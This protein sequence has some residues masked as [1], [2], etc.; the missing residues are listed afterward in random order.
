MSQGKNWIHAPD[1]LTSGHIA[2]L[3]KFLGV[4]EA[5]QP[6]G[7]E[8]VKDC[9]RKLKLDQEIRRAEGGGKIPKAEVT[10]SIDGVA[11]QEPKGKGILHQFPLH[12]ISY[13]ADDKTEKKFFS[14]IAKDGECHR[15]FVFSSE[16]LAEEIT[17]TIGQAF[18]LAYRRF[19]ETSGKEMEFK[20]EIMV[21]QKRVAEL[22]NENSD[23]RQQ[24]NL[25][26]ATV[27]T[28]VKVSKSVDGD[29]D[30]LICPPVPPR[31]SANVANQIFAEFA[32]T[33]NE[34]E[35]RAQETRKSDGLLFDDD[36]I[37]QLDSKPRGSPD[38]IEAPPRISPP[39]KA[40]KNENL[41]NGSSSTDVF[42][43]DPFFTADDPFGMSDFGTKHCHESNKLNGYGDTNGFNAFNGNNNISS[44][45]SN[46]VNYNNISNVFS[47]TALTANYNN[48]TAQ[49]N[50]ANNIK[51]QPQQ[52][53]TALEFLDKKIEEMKVGFSR[54]ILNDDFPLESL[55]PLKSS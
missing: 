35:K 7:I 46:G 12:Q 40:R 22:E 20:R 11:V 6:K 48:I 54:G 41:L 45:G 26:P 13:C 28:E 18:D 36:H 50:L 38:G 32:K 33:A 42:S 9:I 16:K 23:L 43:S 2:Y 27:T 1:A 24:L 34:I 4:T 52:I 17:L 21:L 39:P 25:P 49:N 37:M 44:Y 8:V 55:D 19:L 31:E 14:F 3:V 10:I 47:S 30:L 29:I 15:C 5:E 53:E 51:A